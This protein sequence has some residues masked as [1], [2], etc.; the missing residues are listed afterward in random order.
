M[1][2]LRPVAEFIFGGE[3]RP[4]PEPDIC[5]DEEW[6]AYVYYRDNA[7]GIKREWWYHSPSGTWF[8]AERNTVSDEVL[9]TYLFGKPPAELAQEAALK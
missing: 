9:K 4:M 5:S 7:P 3:Y 1:N 8:I 6:A 2:G